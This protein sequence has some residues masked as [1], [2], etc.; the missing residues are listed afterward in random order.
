M[1]KW[2]AKKQQQE[3]STDDDADH[4]TL[5][6]R[7]QHLQREQKQQ[8]HL[9]RYLQAESAKYK[10]WQQEEQQKRQQWRQQQQQEEAE[11]R[12]RQQQQQQAAVELP[13]LD[14][15]PIAPLYH[16]LRS[17]FASLPNSKSGFGVSC[18][19]AG[20][21]MVSL[22]VHGVCHA[23]FQMRML[24]AQLPAEFGSAEFAR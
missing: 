5:Q 10:R 6:Q 3:D 20:K 23:Q 19:L 1:Q 16:Q 4:E 8:P 17:T 24:A 2:Q 12:E 18:D 22:T 15:L 11:Q 9:Q 7:Q 13:F 14:S 21:H